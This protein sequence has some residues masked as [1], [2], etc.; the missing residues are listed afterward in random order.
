MPEG[1]AYKMFFS[2]VGGG[3]L[4]GFDNFS[5]VI[6]FIKFHVLSIFFT[7]WPLDYHGQWRKFMSMSHAGLFFLFSNHFSS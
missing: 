7:V 4:F 6:K 2:P 1:D 5:T 3:V